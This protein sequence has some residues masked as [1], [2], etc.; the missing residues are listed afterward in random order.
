MEQKIICD[1]KERVRMQQKIEHKF[2][3]HDHI[4]FSVMRVLFGENLDKFDAN[5]RL[6]EGNGRAVASF[7]IKSH[8][9]ISTK[10]TCDDLDLSVHFPFK[11]FEVKHHLA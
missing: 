9:C 5:E 2:Y 8:A 7:Y 1:K 11:D 10:M 6:D 4:P 3:F